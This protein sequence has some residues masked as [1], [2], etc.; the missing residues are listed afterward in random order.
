MTRMR[1]TTG[2][3]SLGKIL[4][5]DKRLYNKYKNSKEL[6]EAL[7]IAGEN[8]WNTYLPDCSVMYRSF[9][10]SG[11]FHTRFQLEVREDD[12][13]VCRAALQYEPMRL[14]TD[15]LVTEFNA[16]LFNLHITHRKTEAV[17][18]V[19]ATMRDLARLMHEEY[20][21]VVE[22]AAVVVE[23]FMPP[24]SYVVLD[25]SQFT[26]RYSHLEDFMFREFA[27]VDVSGDTSRKAHVRMSSDGSRPVLTSMEYTGTDDHIMSVARGERLTTAL[28][29]L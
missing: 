24:T 17:A 27:V 20:P 19:A 26:V 10:S 23:S 7:S 4:G 12:T 29:A 8:K 13:L 5:H 3:A 25:T 6:A 11:I 15:R 14:N 9:K 18:K 22:R 1:K 28:E 21:G 2:V 16:E